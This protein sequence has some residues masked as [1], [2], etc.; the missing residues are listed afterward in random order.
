[1]M[2]HNKKVTLY[3]YIY[4]YIYIHE[5]IF[6]LGLSPHTFVIGSCFETIFV[7]GPATCTDIVGSVCIEYLQRPTGML[8]CFANIYAYI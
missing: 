4:I 8:F 1:M 2:P 7:L 5:V 3:I 6:L